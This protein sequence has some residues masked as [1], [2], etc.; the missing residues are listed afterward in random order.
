[1]TLVVVVDE[2]A[3]IAF[4]IVDAAPATSGLLNKAQAHSL[5]P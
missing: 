4:F 1:M 3:V 2:V 5:S